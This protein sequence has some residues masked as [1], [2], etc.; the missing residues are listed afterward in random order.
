L[1]LQFGRSPGGRKKLE[2]AKWNSR[3]GSKA[4]RSM[5]SPFAGTNDM[6]GRVTASQIAAASP[7]S[8]L[9]RLTYALTYFGLV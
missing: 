7:A 8:V 1:A 4:G 9:S 5:S 6:L 2:R 3:T